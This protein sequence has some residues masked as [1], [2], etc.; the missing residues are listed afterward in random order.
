MRRERGNEGGEIGRRRGER[1]GRGERRRQRKERRE[2]EEN[3]NRGRREKKKRNFTRS[4]LCLIS[5]YMGNKP[6]TSTT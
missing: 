5:M 6:Q 4:M 1:K 3:R 2:E